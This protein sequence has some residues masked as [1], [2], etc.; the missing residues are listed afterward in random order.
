MV[1]AVEKCPGA[2][3]LWLLGA[4]EMLIAGN[5]YGRHKFLEQ[6]YL[7]FP[8]SLDILLEL[9]EEVVWRD[10]FRARDLFCRARLKVGTNTPDSARVWMK[11][12]ICERTLENP[13]DEKKLLTEGIKH[14]P[15]FFK[16]WLMLGQLEERFA[17]FEDAREN[18]QKG[19]HSCPNF[20]P[21]WNSL[22]K[23][24]EKID[25][26][27]HAQDIYS[28][29]REVNP[30]SPELWV[31]E[32]DTCLENGRENKACMLMA[33]A[34]QE[35]PTSGI[36]W[37]THIYIV[38]DDEVE[39]VYRKALSMS[40]N[41]ANVI[42]AVAVFLRQNK[43]FRVAREWFDWAVKTDPD[44]GDVWGLYYR[45]ESSMYRPLVEQRCLAA[46]PKHGRI[47]AANSKTLLCGETLMFTAAHCAT[48]SI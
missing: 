9:A 48:V 33:K 14:F 21:L 37:A 19:L 28:H 45:N 31:A 30:C 12:A 17:R 7:I 1:Y 41:D 43:K 6:A 36:L 18:Y 25:G 40:N 27:L 15:S 29:G 13:V 38:S 5:P 24:V 16:F 42:A 11:S 20:I 3:D 35:C 46:N 10:S 4:R 32:I 8:D 44:N 34:L 39:K 22:A 2:K 47:W 26:F 23:A